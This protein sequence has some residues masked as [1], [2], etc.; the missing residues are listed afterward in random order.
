M[1]SLWLSFPDDTGGTG[2]REPIRR[3]LGGRLTRELVDNVLAIVDGL[4]HENPRGGEL[5]LSHRDDTLLVEVLRRAAPIPAPP[6]TPPSP[7][8]P[9]T[10]ATPA[11]GHARGTHPA[12]TGS[13]MWVE[14]R[15][16][17]LGHRSGD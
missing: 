7:V 16:P 10:P 3:Y 4:V 5:I 12:G 14:V 2:L 9:A 1:D 11:S 13:V 8:S 17:A 15:V 6:A